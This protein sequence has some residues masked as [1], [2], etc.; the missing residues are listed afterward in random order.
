[1]SRKRPKGDLSINGFNLLMEVIHSSKTSVLTISTWHN[2][3]ENGILHGHCRE[4]S[5]LTNNRLCVRHVACKQIRN[6][7]Q[8]LIRGREGKGSAG[9]T[10]LK[11]IL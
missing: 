7:H 8:V 9:E 4:T 1:M 5:N 10:I 2:I 6:E 11:W 3:P